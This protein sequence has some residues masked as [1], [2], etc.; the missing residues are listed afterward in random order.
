LARYTV[1]A[2][3]V[4]QPELRRYLPPDEFAELYPQVA[5]QEGIDPAHQHFFL[6]G[7]GGKQVL[8]QAVID[9]AADPPRAVRKVRE[10]MFRIIQTPGLAQ[11]KDSFLLTVLTSEPSKAQKISQLVQQLAD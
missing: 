2:F 11:M 4:L 6:A 5:K 9:V 1:L 8:G 7:R 10:T 3:C